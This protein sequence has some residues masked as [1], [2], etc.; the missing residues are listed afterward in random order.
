[1]IPSARQVN[2]VAVSQQWLMNARQVKQG[3][4]NPNSIV[5]A[6]EAKS[7]SQAKLESHGVWVV[8]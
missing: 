1:M 3:R 6:M 5:A 7:E 2:T 8:L 4:S